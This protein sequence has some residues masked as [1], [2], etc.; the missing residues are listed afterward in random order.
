MLLCLYRMRMRTE[1]AWFRWKPSMRLLDS[2]FAHHQST[3][4]A[5]AIHYE[6]C[7]VS[8]AHTRSHS[9]HCR[10]VWAQSAAPAWVCL[11]CMSPFDQMKIIQMCCHLLLY[12]RLKVCFV[13]SWLWSRCS[14][15]K[16]VPITRS[17]SSLVK[18]KWF[19][20][21]DSLKVYCFLDSG[22]L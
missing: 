19:P 20:G 1:Y 18:V 10:R 16:N 13:S 22:Q 17:F 21:W 12:E 5:L 3:L 14:V 7:S 9:L 8:H 2:T 6:S 15:L 11:F 4:E